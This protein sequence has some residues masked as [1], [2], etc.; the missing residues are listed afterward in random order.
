MLRPYWKPGAAAGKHRDS[1]A[2]G[3]LHTVLL[4]EVLHLFG[5]R[6]GQRKHG[7]DILLIWLEMPAE[8]PLR[9]PRHS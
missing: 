9:P 8:R 4:Y 3:S 6:M 2:D 5:R 1:E 7:A